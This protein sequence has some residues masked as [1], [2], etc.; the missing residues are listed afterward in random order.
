MARV[1]TLPGRAVAGL[2]LL[3]A[4][5]AIACGPEPD[6]LAGTYAVQ[7]GGAALDVFNALRQEF[8]RRHPSVTLQFLDIGST[9]G[10][11]LVANGS[12]DLATSSAE[13]PSD[14]RDAVRLV[15]IGVSGTAGGGKP[16]EPPPQL[17]PGP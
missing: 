12:S 17:E 5:L 15:S 1:R 7:G 11:R 10:M 2:A 16:R 14:I 8:A 13:P 3:V 4:M 9:P 6:P